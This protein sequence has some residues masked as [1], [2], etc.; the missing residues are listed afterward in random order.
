MFT[1]QVSHIEE[2]GGVIV[3]LDEV[4][5]MSARMAAATGD[6]RWEERYHFFEPQLDAA[7]KETT[8]IRV[9]P[10]DIK[11][12]TKTE[13][14][15]IKLIE[16]EGRAFALLHAGQKEEA[17]TIL[18]SGEYETQKEIYAEATKSF[19]HHAR[20]AFDERLREDQRIDLFSVIAATF[21]AGTSFVAWLSAARSVRRWRAQLLDSVHRRTEAEENLRKAHGELE[22]R[23]KE[24]TAD[25]AKA[26]ETLRTEISER[27]RAEWQLNIQYAVSRVLTE[28]TTLKEA[29][30]R[31]LQTICE[32]LH[33]EV[34]EFYT[35][36][37]PAGVIRFEDVWSAPNAGVDAFIT[38]SRKTTFVR[39]IGLPGRVWASG[40]PVWIPDVSSDEN[41]PRACAAKE[42]GL[43]GAFSVPI[44][45][46]NEVSGV[47]EFFSREIRQP[48]EE[49]LRMFA[50]L[51]S[52]L[53]QFFE[54][55][56]AEETLRESEEKFRQLAD[57]IADVFWITSPDFQTM[58]YV[59]A[60]YELIW[61]RSKETL[62]A[63]PHQ[64]VEA[65]LPEERE[66]VFAVF[67]GLAKN[68]PRVSVEYRIA[69]PDGT[70]RWVHDRGFQVRD[71]A[72]NVVR[73]TG[74]VTDI[75]QRK[76]A[77]AAL[78]SSEAR[79]KAIVDSSLDCII[80][81]DHEGKIL[82]F[83]PAAEQ[84]FG[85]TRAQ[86]L[87]NELA[88]VI[89][90]PALRERHRQGMRHYLATG[91]ARVM[92][93][94]IEISAIRSDGSEFPVELAITRMGVETPPTFTGFIRDIST[95][96]QIEEELRASKR[97]A[98]SIAENS[99]S[100]IYLFDLDTGTTAYT[101]RSV[102]E[103]LGYSQA[104][105]V[106][107]G[108]NALP[109]FVHP[110]DLPRLAQHFAHFADVSDSRVFDLEF[111]VKHASGDWHWLWT[112]E[113]VFNRRADGAAWQIMGTAQDI[114]ERKRAE[115]DLQ[116]RARIA[117][118][119]GEIGAAWT[120]GGTLGEVL[121]LCSDA[122]LRHLDAAF[123]RIWTLNEPEQMLELQASAGLYTHLDGPHSRVPVGKFKIGL[124]AEERKPHL[125]NQVV[126]DPRVGD[127]EWARREGM[128]A[129]AGFPLLVKD[130]VVGVMA[131][132]ARHTLS[133][134]TL[135][136]LGF[137][138]NNIALGIE[139]KRAD[140]ELR[141]ARNAAE[142]ASRAKS[143]F[144]ANMSHEIRT[145][146]N[147]I[148]G[149]TELVLETELDREQR[150]YLGMAKS[151][152]LSLLGL[153]NDILDFSKI[154]AGKL[155]L[156]AISFSLRDCIGTMLKPLGMRADQKGLELTADI[157]AGVPD[158]LIGDPMRLRQIL[159]NLT[160]NAI[161][162]TEKGDVMLRVAV[163]SATDAEHCLHF[164]IADT[165]IGIPA[166]KQAL[167]FD[168]FAQADG[169]TTRT[170]GGTGLG[171]AIASQLVRQM[172][173][174]IW[175]ESTVGE[176]TTFHFTA[177]LPVR[178]TPAPDVRHA[179]P[180][181]LDS[182]RVLVV[183]DNAVNRRILREMLANWRMEP[184]VVASGAAAIVEM[185]RAAR[186][187]TPFPLVILDGMMPE[188]D[189]FM[190]A[191]K[192]REHAEL[193]GATVMML[194]SA[195][196]HGVAARCAELG[197]ASYLT[198]PVGQ[199]E[200]LDAILIAVGGASE[201]EPAG[202]SAPT[203]EPLMRIAS[204]LRILLAEDN[205][206]NRALAAGLL[207][208]R[209]H[210]LVHAATG[211]EALD[212]AAREAFDLIFMDVQMPEMD[213]FEATRLIRESEA[214]I[215]RHTPIV[216]MTAHAMAGDRERCLAA[217]MDDYISKPLQKSEVLELVERIAAG[218]NSAESPAPRGVIKGNPQP[219]LAH[220][221][222]RPFAG[223][224]SGK[225]L[226][227]FSREKLL[228]EL[229]GDEA[230][231]QRMIALFHQNTPR[232]L[233]DIRGSIAR[234]GAIDL[235]RSAHALLSSLGAFGA[236]DARHLT[237][238]LLAHA[239]DE[240]YEHTDRT[241]AALE[242]ETAEIHAALA[243]F[244]PAAA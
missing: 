47:V 237:Q 135:E 177:R 65:I 208:K 227:I 218:R 119:E 226:P 173:G 150:E 19:V 54:R 163:E 94:R 73:L 244:A 168:A 88:R 120:R 55:K 76:R 236:N 58:H 41:F 17:Q 216:A 212:A 190:V 149:M 155:E 189:G 20:H 179:D 52:Q 197:V 231:M 127:Q 131:M 203:V 2:L 59:S 34:G 72:G 107:L 171:L 126:G 97:F 130:R 166:S 57:N 187:G 83:N 193:S 89:I 229:D 30:T 21:V 136:A 160:D 154:E 7:I 169:T 240:N 80:T 167:I 207:E 232:L 3:H 31:I 125:T 32:D 192:I 12:P 5:T 92:G 71:V 230:L 211:R 128:V 182:L 214:A 112:R 117:R 176:G 170:Y 63:D 18:F 152:A 198:K 191:E 105:I 82:E 228:D 1:A 10:S 53:G 84:V 137:I 4:L 159:M 133:E 49:L 101:N 140:E 39:G 14:A 220:S 129:F 184:S 199:S 109:T 102:G 33:W 123:A 180:R 85:Y 146:M 44:L 70:I 50:V 27:K 164:S 202:D 100:F 195:M 81:I 51:G 238:E 132:F 174:R 38:L 115:E 113:T 118:L 106:E 110:E 122:I 15:N 96:K 243:A 93:Q 221:A 201:M 108:E 210:S 139:N 90:P 239:H 209:G 104:Q 13:E 66:R 205:V 138:S 235:A 145:P 142:A 87:G 148:I 28:S 11:T 178:H 213:G 24:R 114:T 215:G 217:G 6:R 194:S 121:H 60:G 77:E 42:A 156:E 165:G 64:W 147:G 185:L 86:V 241:F 242:R 98:E 162:F 29:S 188:M 157:P 103:F 75:T 144:L 224:S 183:D 153:I 62:Y 204:R 37:R 25:L 67:L 16:M 43:H 175:V 91:E 219:E 186:A 95:R 143:E 56:R 223:E 22:A 23:V 161:K 134:V 141:I 9:G 151:S 158:H 46:G 35:V 68:E 99:T 79:T 225:A 222:L 36:D 116:E 111:R 45:I 74:I 78:L 172:G 206:I 124:I 181:Q 69:R 40:K 26:N 234:H 233:E 8:K 48:D 61:G 200:L 196:P